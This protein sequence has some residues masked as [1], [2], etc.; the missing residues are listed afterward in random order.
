MP[1][2]RVVRAERRG[3]LSGIRSR[4][5]RHRVRGGSPVRVVSILGC[6]P[7]THHVSGG[8][9]AEIQRLRRRRARTYHGHGKQTQPCCA[10][11]QRN[12]AKIKRDGACGGFR[13]KQIVAVVHHAV[14]VHV[15]VEVKAHKIRTL[16]EGSV[17]PGG[18]LHAREVDRFAVRGQLCLEDRYRVACVIAGADRSGRWRRG[19]QR[20]SE[21]PDRHGV[22]RRRASRGYR[23]AGLPACSHHVA[24][25]RDPHRKRATRYAV[26]RCLHRNKQVQACG[27][28]RYRH[29]GDPAERD[30]GRGGQSIP[31]LGV[32]GVH[33]AV[34]ISIHVQSVKVDFRGNHRVAASCQLDA[35]QVDRF[36]SCHQFELEHALA[37][38]AEFKPPGRNRIGSGRSRKR[39]GA[40]RPEKRHRIRGGG[41]HGVLRDG[42]GNSPLD[43]AIRGDTQR[44]CGIGCRVRRNMTGRQQVQP[45]GRGHPH[46]AEAVEC[47][48]RRELRV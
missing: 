26:G 7:D 36:A 10:G 29:A 24:R 2:R 38:G 39:A 46:V 40:A 11:G 43:F 31:D 27:A 47:Y 13:L 3:K 20:H 12:P 48:L 17:A 42:A 8:G 1:R 35:C 5:D 28:G 19:A 9:D 32:T 41:A 18:D 44:D 6:L 16:S 30:R 33:H 21:A 45:R 34:A 14:Q 25:G 4:D 22:G 23:C 37:V 15:I